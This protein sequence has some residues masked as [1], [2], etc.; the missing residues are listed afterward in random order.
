MTNHTPLHA[1]HLAAGARMVDFGGWD[2][3][4]HYGSQLEEHHLVRR[5]AGI[6]DVS[7]M[8]IVDISGR[9][10]EVFLRRLLAN[11][12][13]KLE[14]PGRGLYSCMLN[15]SGGIVDDLISYR[16]GERDYR[17]VVNAA[18]RAG[19]LAW[20]QAV[21]G[22]FDVEVAERPEAVMLA[23]QGPSAVDRAASLLPTE[24][25]EAAPSLGSFCCLESGGVF[26]AR[27]GYTG[28]DG[29]EVIFDAGGGLEFWDASAAAGIRPCG[30]GARDTLRLEA[31]LC[32]YGQDM[33]QQTSPLISGLGWTVAWEPKERDF[34][35]RAALERDKTDASRLK[36][37]G[38][39]LE[40]RGIMRHGQRVMTSAGD[41]VVTSGGFS[42]TIQRSIALARTPGEAAGACQVESRK[43]HR[44]AKIVRPPFV[45][46]GKILV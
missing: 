29:F 26:V 33:D 39:I 19:D 37:A 31:G 45:R 36:L 46:N 40:D 27:T 1:R 24:L 5:D 25:R 7:H 44:A 42:P 18:T 34:V 28:E 6:F 10:A 38:L 4:L 15:E 20:M 32:L 22:T 21:A 3:P 17:V 11:D 9:D 35:G 43:A 23:V 13:A 30:L 8:T 12:V 16:R 2:M 14:S 41:G